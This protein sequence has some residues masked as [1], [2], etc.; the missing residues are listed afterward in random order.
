MPEKRKAKKRN[1]DYKPV[2]T[3]AENKLL[4]NYGVGDLMDE[5]GVNRIMIV[6]TLDKM[7]QEME[8]L[9]FRDH[10]DAMRAMA[11]TTGRIA[12]LLDTRERLY[13]PYLEERKQF[14]EYMDEMNQIIENFSIS[15]LG[16]EKYDEIQAEALRQAMVKENNRGKNGL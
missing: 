5:V 4:L 13:Q 16:Q 10:L 3:N 12:S 15:A 9:S 7:N 14:R 6:R 1:S 8:N 2:F 11:Y